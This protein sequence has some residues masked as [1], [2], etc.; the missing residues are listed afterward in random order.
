MTIVFFLIGKIKSGK[1]FGFWEFYNESGQ[2]FATGNFDTNGQR[3]GKWVWFNSFNKIKT[4]LLQLSKKATEFM[5]KNLVYRLE[6]S[7]K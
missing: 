3:S 4:L 2:N 5:S 6:F 1:P 7:T